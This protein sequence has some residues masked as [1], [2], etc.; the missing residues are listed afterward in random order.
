MQIIP[1]STVA[2][3]DL[4]NVANEM[5]EHCHAVKKKVLVRC[6][7]RPARCAATCACLHQW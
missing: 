1:A 4:D 5:E 3:L 7:L 6:P 2:D